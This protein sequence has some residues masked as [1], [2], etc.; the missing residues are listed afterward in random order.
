MGNEDIKI[1]NPYGLDSIELIDY[2]ESTSSN[3]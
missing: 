1:S 3:D 2:L